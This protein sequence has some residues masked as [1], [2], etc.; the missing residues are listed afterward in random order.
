MVISDEY[1]RPPDSRAK[2]WTTCPKG[3][4]AIAY[5]TTSEWITRLTSGTLSFSCRSCGTSFRI[6]E[7]ERA[8]LL[9]D[10]LARE[11]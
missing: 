10:C 2:R 6:P 4:E 11:F 5:Y 3:H 9:A 7:D 8:R 1:A